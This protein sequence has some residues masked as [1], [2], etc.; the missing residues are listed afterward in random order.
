MEKAIRLSRDYAYEFGK[1]FFLALLIGFLGKISIFMPMNPIPLAFRPQL[2]IMIAWLMGSKRTCFALVL[3]LIFGAF[4]NTFLVTA[5]SFSQGLFGPTFGYIFGYFV[6]A[7]LAST[8]KQ[9][10]VG[11]TASFLLLSCLL[12]LIGALGL[13]LFLG[14]PQGFSLG[15]FPF[16]LGDAAKSIVCASA[17]GYL[18]KVGR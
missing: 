6:V 3:F 4:E 13:A 17:V 8:L 7:S 5:K 12:D 14:I 10:G 15:F 11:A 2:V 16:I 9:R 18:S 1:V